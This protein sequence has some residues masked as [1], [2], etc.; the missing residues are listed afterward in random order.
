MDSL[1]WQRVLVLQNGFLGDTV[2]TLPLLSEIKLRYPSAKLV[3][4]CSPLAKELLQGHPDIDEIIVDDKKGSDRGLLGIWRKA[5]T[6]KKM[7]FTVAFTPHK[8]LRSALML[9]FAGIPLRVGFRQSAASF[10]FHRRVTREPQ[11]H[12]VERNL[13]LLRAFGIQPEDCRRS[14]RLPPGCGAEAVVKKILSSMGVDEKKMLIGINPGSVW[15][16]KR[17]S[18]EGF[19][20]AIQ[21]IRKNYDCDVVLFG[22]PADAEVASRIQDLCGGTLVNLAGRIGLNEMPAALNLCRVLITNDSAP[23]HMA[24]ACGVPTVA[25]FCATTPALGFYPYSDNAILLEKDL[26]CR[27]C[28]SHGG[29]RCPLGTE[30]CI[31]LISPTHVLQAVVKLLERKKE[32]APAGKDAFSPEFISV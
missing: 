16:T 29:R 22:G 11:R 26:S 21:L 5:T 27:P 19:A 7:S 20:E 1:A 25:I 3:L 24:V 12:D 17:W 10:L 2:L 32:S 9:Y 13:S 23:M 31:R 8:S 6:L 14:M 15:A 28:G 30:D 18:A 4:A